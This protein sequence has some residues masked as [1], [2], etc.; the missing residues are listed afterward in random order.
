MSLFA[1]SLKNIFD[2]SGFY[3]SIEDW[4]YYLGCDQ[5]YKYDEWLM[6]K[7]L[8]RSSDLNM[9]WTIYECGIYNI[10]NPEPFKEFEKLLHVRATEISPLGAQMLP[11]VYEYMKR[12]TFCELSDILAKLTFAEQGKLLLE[13]YP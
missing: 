9:I 2:N 3:D 10:P 8:P 5:R 13:M 6:D 7:S 1:V 4:K 11:T 12:P